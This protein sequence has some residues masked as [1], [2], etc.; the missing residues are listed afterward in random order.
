MA[1]LRIPELPQCTAEELAAAVRRTIQY[2]AD[3]IPPTSNTGPQIRLPCPKQLGEAAAGLS[4]QQAD[5]AEAATR[6]TALIEAAYLVA[7]A[8]GLDE[9][10]HAALAALVCHAVGPALDSAAVQVLFDDFARKREQ[11]G[12]VARLDAVSTHFRHRLERQEVMSFAV[13]VAM[14]DRV[15][16]SAE[17]D[18]LVALGERFAFKQGVTLLIAHQVAGALERALAED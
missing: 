4:G 17:Q 7:S 3:Q 1:R 6:I 10:E 9:Q 12:E 16:T 14:S 15:L 13:L 18:T 8:D 5:A 2:Q 11:Q